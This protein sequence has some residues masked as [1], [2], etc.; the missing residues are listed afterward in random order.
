M[1]VNIFLLKNID[2]L[3]CCFDFLLIFDFEV[4]VEILKFEQIA[5]ITVKNNNTIIV[6]IFFL[7]M[8]L[9]LL[10]FFFVSIIN[11]P[12]SRQWS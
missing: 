6:L 3:F 12:L 7:L 2:L 8:L 9:I 11:D 5:Y 1:A 10:L 4:L